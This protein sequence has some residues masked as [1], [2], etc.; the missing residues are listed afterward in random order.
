MK[1]KEAL[2]I[3]TLVNFEGQKSIDSKA[4]I[5]T[6]K[7]SRFVLAPQPIRSTLPVSLFF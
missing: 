1:F 5:I 3:N 7:K 4:L 2:K 6:A